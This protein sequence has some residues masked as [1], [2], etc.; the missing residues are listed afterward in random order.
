MILTTTLIAIT[1]RVV[2]DF[3]QLGELDVAQQVSLPDVDSYLLA[4]FRIGQGTYLAKKGSS[5]LGS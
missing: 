2:T 3:L 1:T 4:N 5:N